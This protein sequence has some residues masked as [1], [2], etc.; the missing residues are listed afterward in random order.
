MIKCYLRLRLFNSKKSM[1]EKE[2]SPPQAFQQ[3]KCMPE[4]EASA[5]VQ[6][7]A[8]DS[9]TLFTPEKRQLYECR[10]QEGYDLRDP[11]YG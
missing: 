10:F 11:E 3:Q 4:Q 5:S 8:T 9:S 7:T 6:E 1:S 2:I